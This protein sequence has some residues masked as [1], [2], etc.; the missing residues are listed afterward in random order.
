VVQKFV[1]SKNNEKLA[2]IGQNYVIM[3]SLHRED[4]ISDKI[5][6]IFGF[7]GTF[8]MRFI[9]VVFSNTPYNRQK[10][11]KTVI[12]GHFPIFPI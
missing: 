7:L 9:L 10:M 6:Q 11:K 12:F 5:I 3:T 2:K 1:L 8:C 4:E